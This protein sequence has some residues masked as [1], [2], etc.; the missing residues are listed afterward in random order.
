MYI[1]TYKYID[2]YILVYVVP[3]AMEGFRDGQTIIGLPNA[4]V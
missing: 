2:M 3:H 4:I 1:Y